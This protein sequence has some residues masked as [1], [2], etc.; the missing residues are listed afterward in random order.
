MY[1][2]SKRQSLR[3]S[4]DRYVKTVMQFLVLRTGT[5]FYLFDFNGK[6]RTNPSSENDNAACIPR[7]VYMEQLMNILSHLLDCENAIL[8]IRAYINC[9]I[10]NKFN[11][12]PHVVG[13]SNENDV[14]E[15]TVS[16]AI[17]LNS[18]YRLLLCEQSARPCLSCTVWQTLVSGLCTCTMN[19]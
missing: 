9:R 19:V 12:N 3:R 18:F 14:A 4:G 15:R 6:S 16:A 7:T 13:H 17:Q 10:G 8:F 1:F 11:Y 2:L 5:K